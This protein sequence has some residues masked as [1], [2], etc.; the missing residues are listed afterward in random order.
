[1]TRRTGKAAQRPDAP[2][3]AALV[4]ISSGGCIGLALHGPA[5]C[6]RDASPAGSDWSLRGNGAL[7]VLRLA[8]LALIAGELLWFRRRARYAMVCWPL[9]LVSG[10]GAGA[11]AGGVDRA[12]SAG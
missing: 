4:A 10:L 1:M 3:R 12:G 2:F 11:C 8:A 6:L 7:V 9:P 5:V